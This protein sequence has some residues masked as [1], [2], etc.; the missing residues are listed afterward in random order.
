PVVLEEWVQVGRLAS[1][2]RE[3]LEWI[4]PEGE[5]PEEE[6]GGGHERG[7]DPRHELAVPLAVLQLHDGREEGEH[8]DPEEERALLSPPERGDRVA[9]RQRAR[10][11]GGHVLEREVV[12]D[13]RVEED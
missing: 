9:E 11:V 5:E 6:G 10:G 1:G 8:E 4:G 13:E 2:D 7:G 12:L 3:A